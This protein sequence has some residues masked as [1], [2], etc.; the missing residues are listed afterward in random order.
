MLGVQALLLGVG[1]AVTLFAG[2]LDPLDLLMRS[3]ALGLAGLSAWLWGRASTR[4]AV[5]DAAAVERD[6]VTPTAARTD[7]SDVL[8]ELSVHGTLA[9]WSWDLRSAK[10]RYADSCATM[11]GYQG[12]AIADSIASWGKLVHGDDLPRV[13]AALDA[14]IEGRSARYESLVR[15]QAA[16]RSWRWI[17]DVGH[18]VERDAEGRALRAVGAH[19]D[20]T[21]MVDQAVAILDDDHRLDTPS[22]PRALSNDAPLVLVVDDDVAQRLI[23]GAMLHRLGY[24]STLAAN[25]R[26]ALSM[27]ERERGEFAAVLSDVQMPELDGP[28]LARE[29]R[30]RGYRGP[31]ILASGALD[32]RAV[33]SIR[34][35]DGFLSKPFD[36]ETLAKQLPQ[37]SRN[38]LAGG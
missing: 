27:Y 20:V 2:P 14:H 36:V 29:L 1:G 31:L 32:V 28:A 8:A 5:D 3:P 7:L 38:S 22:A 37:V 30:S 35:A 23:T 6:E 11:L 25:G 24:R 19:V 34:E 26:A 18:V 16:D 15:V 33:A 10:I 12:G 4:A 13:R 17:L 21:A 9:E